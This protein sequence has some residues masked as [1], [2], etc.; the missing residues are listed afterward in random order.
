MLIP[1][2]CGRARVQALSLLF[3]KLALACFF[4]FPRNGNGKKKGG[5]LA[6]LLVDSLLLLFFFSSLK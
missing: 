6:L 2:A 1:L 4:C 5:G 3:P